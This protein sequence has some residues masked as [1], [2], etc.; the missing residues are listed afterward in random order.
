MKILIAEDDAFIRGVLVN[1]LREWGHEVVETRDGL[2]A[3]PAI[4]LSKA[5]FVIMD[6]NMPGVDGIELCR[7][8]RC[9]DEQGYVYV[10]FL[11]VKDSRVDVI[12]ALEAGAD[13][14]MSKPFDPLELRARVR[15]G[16]RILELERRLLAENDGLQ[17]RNEELKE[18]VTVD[19]LTGVGNRRALLQSLERAHHRFSRYGETYGIAM[20][21][22]DHFKSYNDGFGHMAGDRALRSVSDALKGALRTS[23]E[24]FR[25]GGEELL[26]LTPK[27]TPGGMA[28]FGERLRR[29]VEELRIEHPKSATGVLTVS[30]GLTIADG[31]DARGR[32]E[33]VLQRADQ[34]LYAAK[35]GG[36]NTVRYRGG[37]LVPEGVPPTAGKARA[38]RASAAGNA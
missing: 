37:D 18:L 21:D 26:V 24:I 38:A 27:Q 11:T 29:S 36:R 23:D 3:L 4:A 20:C 34:A 9:L 12:Q 6:W 14:Y 16:E 25:F 17:V 28:T 35:S 32:W 22:V 30:C 5:K 10:V 2:E 33:D 31:P 15:T 19:P 1:T 13:D 8:V 7:R